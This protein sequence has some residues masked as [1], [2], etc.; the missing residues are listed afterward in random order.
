MWDFLRAAQAA[1]RR[2]A[3]SPSPSST[4]PAAS[5]QSGAAPV[6]G[7][8]GVAPGVAVPVPLPLLAVPGDEAVVAPPEEDDA[9]GVADE[10]PDELPLEDEPPE[11]DPPA[12]T[13]ST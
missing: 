11:E 12:P 1:V 6:L 13:T 9:G 10:P 8:L 2:R 4:A 5:R 7:R 3:T